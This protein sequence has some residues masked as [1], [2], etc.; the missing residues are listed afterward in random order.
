MLSETYGRYEISMWVM[1]LLILLLV[2]YEVWETVWGK[3]KANRRARQVKQRSDTIFLL[4]GA[5]LELMSAAP[6][7]WAHEPDLNKAR[8]EHLKWCE[9]VK[10]WVL[11]AGNKLRE[12]PATAT[13]VFMDDSTVTSADY[14]DVHPHVHRFYVLLNRKMANLRAIADKP[15]RYL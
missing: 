6:S 11:Q 5:A 3:I 14:S 12:F 1:E 2:G 13:G 10:V 8:E 4:M 15:E 9:S 7:K